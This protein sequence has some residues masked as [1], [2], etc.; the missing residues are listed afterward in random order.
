MRLMLLLR[1]RPSEEV[2]GRR[3]WVDCREDVRSLLGLLFVGCEE[4]GLEEWDWSSR[5][6]IEYVRPRRPADANSGSWFVGTL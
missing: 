2:G 3:E 4:V 6:R 5:W 1:A